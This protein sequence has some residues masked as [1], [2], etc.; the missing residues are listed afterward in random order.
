M[1]RS[2]RYTEYTGALAIPCADPPLCFIQGSNSKAPAPPAAGTTG[3]RP[4]SKPIVLAEL[5]G[6]SVVFAVRSS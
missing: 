4:T 2:L 3:L 5:G 1:K 6:L